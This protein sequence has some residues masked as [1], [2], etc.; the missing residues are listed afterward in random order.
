MMR[1]AV[2]FDRDGTLMREVGYCSNPRDVAV[3]D[4]AR[5]AVRWLRQSLARLHGGQGGESDSFDFELVKQVEDFQRDHR[6]AI[7]GIAGR[8]T[9]M[10][11]DSALAQPDTPL[12]S[13]IPEPTPAR[14]G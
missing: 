7:D 2:F 14:G 5:E 11:L 9:Q 13:S 1:P 10:M 8:Q 6:L 12:L 3:L 4:G